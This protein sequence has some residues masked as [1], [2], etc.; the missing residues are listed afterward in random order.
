MAVITLNIAAKVNEAPTSGIGSLTLEYNELYVFTLADFTTNTFPSY[1]DPE[2]DNLFYVKI[3]SLPV[4][5]T[6]TLSAVAVTLGQDVIN[7]DIS[8]GNLKY[9]ADPADT[10]GYDTFFNFAVSDEGSSNFSSTNPFTVNVDDKVNEPPS[11]V[12]DGTATVDYGNT[13][14]FTRAMF[15][16]GTTPPYADPEAD[17]ALLLKIKTLSTLGAI[18]LSGTNVIVDQIIDFSDIDL[19]LLTYVPDNADTDGDVQGFTFEIADAG[20]GIFVA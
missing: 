20:S 18:K 10:N 1:A 16:T 5:G 12:G 19:G 6:L 4:T 11:E 15:T 7:S 13:L 2:G 14:V 17:A 8:G 3:V 9:Q